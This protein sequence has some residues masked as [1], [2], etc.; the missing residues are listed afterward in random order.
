MRSW[1]QNQKTF[2]K[3]LGYEDWEEDRLAAQKSHLNLGKD[4]LK[5]A[6]YL[7]SLIDTKSQVELPMSK[8]VYDTKMMIL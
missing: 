7:G 1:A 4:P 2:R 6:W 5:G 3:N 8:K